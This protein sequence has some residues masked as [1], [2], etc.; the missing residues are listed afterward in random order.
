VSWRRRRRG[1]GG[2]EK[3]GGSVGWTG[4]SLP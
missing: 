2:G 1:R 3:R 4:Y